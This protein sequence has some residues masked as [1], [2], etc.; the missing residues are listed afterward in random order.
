MST[1]GKT[2]FIK[3]ELRA[4]EPLTIDGRME[5][6][7]HCEDEELV[8]GATAQITGDIVAREITV[9]GSV[10]GQLTAVDVIDV[11][12]D[13]NITGTAISKRFILH[14]GGVFQGRVEPQHLEAA[15]R[16]AKHG[17]QKR[18]AAATVVP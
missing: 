8:L 4:S 9:F 3:G 13:S 10:K 2:I 17:Q 7:I 14:D 15:L 6:T 18:D 5:G 12:P 16:V 1:I 11:R